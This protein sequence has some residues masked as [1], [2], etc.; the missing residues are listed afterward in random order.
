MS[1]ENRYLTVS[2]WKIETSKEQNPCWTRQRSG[3]KSFAVVDSWEDVL[4]DTGQPHCQIPEVS[5]KIR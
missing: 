5:Y 3:G 2:R 4:R 1:R